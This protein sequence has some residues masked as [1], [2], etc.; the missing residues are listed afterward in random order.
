MKAERLAETLPSFR[1]AFDAAAARFDH[2]R[3]LPPDASG[4]IRRA[5]LAAASTLAPRILDLG[6]GSG[7]IGWP[8]VA[9]GDD[10]VG[11]DLSL[12]MLRAFAARDDLGPRA[13]PRLVQAEGQQLPFADATFDV[14]MLMQVF[15][16]QGAWRQLL[17]EA[18]RVLRRTGILVLGRTI[19]PDDGV[20]GRMK[21]RLDEILAG[22]GALQ[23]HKNFGRDAENLLVSTASNVGRRTAAQWLA[24]RSPRAFLDRHR[25]GARFSRL[26]EG[27]K[28][29]ALSRLAGW[30]EKY[31]GSLDA[32]SSEQ[33]RFQ[34]HIFKFQSEAGY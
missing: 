20:D 34:L 31:F 8:F 11:A 9:A 6:A 28:E 26:P 19:M 21:Q 16:G 3:A 33:H 24:A 1:S 2:H 10:Y 25:T 4:T 30:A 22:L 15:G 27:V 12:G 5:V 23:E 32:S 17:D 18:K 13:T 14:V 29:E 7:R